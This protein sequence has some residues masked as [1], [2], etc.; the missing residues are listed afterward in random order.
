M[1]DRDG[2]VDREVGAFLGR[3][4]SRRTVG[5][6]SDHDV[7]AAIV[8][9]QAAQ[10]R[11]SRAVV[12]AGAAAL[13]LALVVVVVLALGN[14]QGLISAG[15]TAS[16]A[17]ATPERVLNGGLSCPV[18]Q[19]ADLTSDLPA[20]SAFGTGPVHAVFA[21]SAGKA[22]FDDDFGVW[23]RIDMLW[24]AEPGYSG[25][26]VVRGEQLRGHGEVSFGDAAEQAPSSQVVL[27]TSQAAPLGQG[28][29]TLLAEMPMRI[30]GPGCYEIEIDTGSTSS[31]FV[32]EAGTVEDAW[33]KLAR[34]LRLPSIGAGQACPAT[35]TTDKVQFVGGAIGDGPVYLAG[36]GGR[37]IWLTD[38]RELGPILIRSSRIDGSGELLFGTDMFLS[39]QLRLPIHSYVTSLGQSP[40]WRQFVT[41]TRASTDGCYA[42]QIDTLSGSEVLIF[43][44]G[45]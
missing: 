43:N 18:S 27:D 41:S 13:G 11:L 36:G 8:A 23:K 15:S 39:P 10:P 16:P 44:L 33:V 45:G 7:V 32:F 30:R 40:G 17:T 31:V 9:G 26:V 34:P 6:R 38:T 22:F 25:Q 35:P 42:A 21:E 5:R 1:D 4:A 12:A 3:E 19:G 24:V 2:S 14:F 29:W 20:G 37:A 28:G